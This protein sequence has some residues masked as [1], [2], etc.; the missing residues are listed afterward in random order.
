MVMTG[1]LD[2]PYRELPPA[3]VLKSE[4]DK[5]YIYGKKKDGWI[6][7][8]SQQRT[9]AGKFIHKDWYNLP[10]G[11]E[12][13]KNLIIELG[14][15]LGKARRSTLKQYIE[16]NGLDYEEINYDDYST[17]IE[18][19]YKSWISFWT[20]GTLCLL[21]QVGLGGSW[22]LVSKYGV[23]EGIEVSVAAA[24]E[25]QLRHGL[26]IGFIYFMGKNM[27]AQTIR[28][29]R[30][31][32]KGVTV[33]E[34]DDIDLVIWGVGINKRYSRKKA[35]HIRMG[36]EIWQLLSVYAG[37]LRVGGKD[38]ILQESMYI[39]IRKGWIRWIEDA[40]NKGKHVAYQGRDG[41]RLQNGLD[42]FHQSQASYDAK[43]NKVREHDR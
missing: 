16:K 27:A 23:M 10:F 5:G 8:G 37:N 43:Y 17:A 40:I 19:N 7:W 1:W 36:G 21:W 26:M 9:E 13:T 30:R 18:H 11:F 25:W 28:G 14:R 6:T 33:F 24:V 34:W 22:C 32:M 3:R 38:V 15:D 4:R 12:G 39:G 41:F 29:Y 31:L 2:G 35:D 42:R 20:G